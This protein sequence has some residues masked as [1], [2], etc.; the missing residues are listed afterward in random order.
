[1]TETAENLTPSSAG[2][3]LERSHRIPLVATGMFVLMMLAI[4][5]MGRSIGDRFG[6]EVAGEGIEWVRAG[7]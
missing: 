1:M 2:E 3:R 5:L 4:W 7:G 6:S